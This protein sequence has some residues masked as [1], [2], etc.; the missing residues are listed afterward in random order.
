MSTAAPTAKS[1]I[2]LSLSATRNTLMS[3]CCVSLR[4]QFKCLVQFLYFCMERS[5]KNPI[6]FQNAV[7]CCHCGIAPQC[8]EIACADMREKQSTRTVNIKKTR[9]P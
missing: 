9:Y 2:F 7:V 3:Q 8:P 1:S 5:Q 6:F 4:E